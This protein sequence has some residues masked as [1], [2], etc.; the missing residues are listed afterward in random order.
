MPADENRSART[1]AP[2]RRRF[3][4]LARMGPST[5]A[6]SAIPNPC[7]PRGAST[8]A[9]TGAKGAGPRAARTAEA[10]GEAR[11]AYWLKPLGGSSPCNGM[12][13]VKGIEP[14]YSAWKAD[15]NDPNRGHFSLRRHD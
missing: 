13:R 15:T 1:P 6:A 9:P 2:R 12:E 3:E 7:A 14:S 8:I 10:A 11:N 5:F 4:P